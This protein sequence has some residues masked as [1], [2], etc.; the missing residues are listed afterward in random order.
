IVWLEEAA[1][2]YR[3]ALIHISRRKQPAD[4]GL[5]KYRL[6]CVLYKVDLAIGDD[7]ALREAIHAC[8]AARQVFS[9]Y[10]HPIRWSEIS[11]TLAQILQ[12]YGD[13]SRSV[14]LLEYAVRCCV[15]SLQV[16]TPDTAPLQWASIQ[17]TLGSALFL[18]AKHTGEWEYM[19]QSSEAF[20]MALLVYRDHGAGRMAV[21]TERNLLRAD[22]QVQAS[23][24][25]HQSD[26]VWAQSF[27]ITDDDAYD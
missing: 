19:R 1:D 15:A 13:N 2:A 16:R 9:R 21:I 7:N 10:A 26:P 8:Q 22:K 6:G 11:N 12:V 18:L 25:K 24:E 23:S 14:P 27:N 4:W 5:M 3:R 20:R 17:N